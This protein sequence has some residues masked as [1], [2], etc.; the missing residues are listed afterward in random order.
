MNKKIEDDLTTTP[1]QQFYDL[2]KK[3]ELFSLQFQGIYYWQL[4]RTRILK[5]IY[6]SNTEMAKKNAKRAIIEE[7]IGTYKASIKMRKNFRNLYEVDILRLRPCVALSKNGEL[8]DHQYDYM[9]GDSSINFM[10]V[11]V[12]GSY[13][14]MPNCV[15]FSMAPAEWKVIIWKIKRKLFGVKRIDKNQKKLLITFI[16]KINDVYGTNINIDMLEKEIFYVVCC[17][18]KYSKFLKKIFQR[19]HPKAV[20]VYPHYDDHMFAAIDVCK[21]MGIK[22]IEIQH[23]LIN[24]HYSYWYEDQSDIGKN[25]P[26]Y[27]FTYSEWWNAQIKMPEYCKPIAVGNA[28]LDNQIEKFPY[29]ESNEVV[30]TVLSSTS[31]GKE[32]SKFIC[33]VDEKLNG[34]NIKILYKLHPNE[35]KIWRT[36]YSCLLNTKNVEVIDDETS[37][38]DILSRSKIV[39][40]ITSTTLF[41]ATVYD[42]LTIIIYLKSNY[43]LMSPLLNSGRAIGVKNI[44]ELIDVLYNGCDNDILNSTMEMELWKKDAR[45]NIQESLFH[46]L[47]E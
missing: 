45:A 2:E 47:N 37:I 31:N 38:Y 8:D 26:N 9:K 39:L 32:L 40:G 41:E 1:Y 35:R 28:Y 4:V 7:I 3:M 16:D 18:K 42:K 6:V 34:S 46:I 27:I 24:S 43:Y 30:L 14:K 5:N 29:K 15:E 13:H 17:H 21:R 20:M 23:G 22:S 10:D 25:L 11:Y 36:E 33:Q 19:V 44:D 12:L